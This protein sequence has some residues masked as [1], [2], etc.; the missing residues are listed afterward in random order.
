MARS[1]ISTS[2][3]KM[4]SCREKQRSAGVMGEVSCGVEDLAGVEGLGGL[5]DLADLADLVDLV[6]VGVEFWGERCNWARPSTEA[7]IPEKE[8]SIPLTAYGRSTSC[9][10]LLFTCLARSSVREAGGESIL[11]CELLNV[12]S[13]RRI[14]RYIQRSSEPIKTVPNG[15]VYCLTKNTISNPISFHQILFAQLGGSMPR[16]TYRCS[17]YAITCVFP[18][19]T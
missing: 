5:D 12:I 4:V 18:P 8:Q 1:V 2:M 7:R 19:E 11:L 17:A 15:N 3:L 10:P 6:G 9:L 13:G 16:V 14:V